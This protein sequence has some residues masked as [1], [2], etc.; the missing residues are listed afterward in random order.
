MG[1]CKYCGKDAGFLSNS[2]SECKAKHDEGVR[3]LTSVLLACFRSKQDFY[4]RAAEINRIMHDAYIE[5]KSKEDIYVS[6]LDTAIEE[7]LGDGII[8]DAEKK[9]VARYIQFSNLPQ[10]ILNRNH[11]IEKMLQAEVISDILNG[12]IP[13][14]KIRIESNFPFML[15]KSENLVWLFRNITLH[16]QKI[17][18]EYVGRNRGLSF[19]ICKGVYYRTGGFKG[20][21]IEKTIMQRISIGTVCLTDKHIYYHSPERSFKIPYSKIINIES[22]SNGVGIHKDGATS[23]PIF[24]EN[25]D[26]WFCYNVIANL[27]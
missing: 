22:Y 10:D 8:D 3:D 23:K 11:A 21:P 26:S 9:V 7:Y 16:E 18:K 25:L 27:K 19:R 24:F 20:H 14:P 13:A 15:Q 12:K 2:H 1:A 6:V 4:L 5:A 17:Q